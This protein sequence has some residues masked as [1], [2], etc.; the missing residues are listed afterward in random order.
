MMKKREEYGMMNNMKEKGDFMSRPLLMDNHMHTTVSGDSRA[1]AEE[2]CRSA[3]EKGFSIITFTDHCEV[4]KVPEDFNR[5]LVS[6]TQQLCTDM[7]CQFPQLTILFGTEIGQ[8]VQFPRRAQQIVEE[9]PLDFVLASLHNTK[10]YDDFS[11][12]NYLDPAFNIAAMFE[13]HYRE[14]LVMA[15]TGDFD[16]LAHLT[17]PFR[18]LANFPELTVDKNQFDDIIDEILKAVVARGKAL[19]INTSGLRQKIGETLPGKKFLTRYRELGGELLTIG[20]DAH[21]P[22]D[23][24]AGVEQGYALAQAC[25]FTHIAYYRQRKPL[26]VKL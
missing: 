11:A 25:G 9:F 3:V 24:G 10:G 8:M 5:M 19:E 17:Y 22:G 12:I 4:D 21:L 6:L 7:R 13:A 20:S 2:L 26:L 23:L 16:S 14:M 18:Y 1:P 15:Q